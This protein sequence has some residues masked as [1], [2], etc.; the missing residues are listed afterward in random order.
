[1]N[2]EARLRRSQSCT[3]PAA[4]V[5]EEG[6]YDRFGPLSRTKSLPKS[7]TGPKDKENAEH[8]H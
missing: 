5:E 3:T 8:R 6:G 2:K 1:M 4:D 7:R